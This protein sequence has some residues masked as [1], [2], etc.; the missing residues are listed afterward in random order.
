MR[1]MAIIDTLHLGKEELSII[2]AKYP[3]CKVTN[4]SHSDYSIQKYRV[5]IPN[6]DGCVDSYY[7]FLIE[8]G[9]AMSSSNFL[10]RIVSDQRFVDRMRTK[11]YDF[12]DKTQSK[13]RTGS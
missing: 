5:I 4:Q 13:T 7:K 6:E 9:I 1:P 8:N 12:A 3:D 2:Q 11:V 10:G